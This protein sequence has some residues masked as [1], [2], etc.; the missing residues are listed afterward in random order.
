MA[1]SWPKWLP[2][3]PRWGAPRIHGELQKLGIEVSERTVSR[4]L[5]R[6]R[7]RLPSLTWRTFLANHAASLVSMDFFTVPTLTGRVLFVFMLLAHQRRRIVHFAITDHPTAAWMAQQIIDAFPDET[8]PRWLVKDRDAIYSD[9]FRRRVAGMGIADVVSAPSSPCQNP[10]AERLVGS[11]RR[12]CLDRMIILSQRHCVACL[13][14]MAP[15]TIRAGRISDWRRTRPRHDASKCRRKVA[16]SRSGKSVDLILST[17]DAQPDAMRHIAMATAVSDRRRLGPRANRAH[18][19]AVTSALEFI[20]VPA[21]NVKATCTKPT[22]STVSS[23]RTIK[24][25]TPLAPSLGEEDP[26]ESVT[27]A[28]LW[29][30][31]RSGQG[32]QLLTEREILERDSAVSPAEQS[33]RSEE[34]D[35]HRQH[36]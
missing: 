20:A 36:S 7:G 34:Y 14:D 8:A 13:L 4:L 23:S 9:V 29:A 24:G 17:S 6:R 31:A 28:E 1:Y 3:I 18:L 33:D 32:G 35:Q 27:P 22:R 15:I 21:Q 26:E 16:L 12:E 11:L 10:Y 5:Q 2:Q 30:L 25:S 19:R